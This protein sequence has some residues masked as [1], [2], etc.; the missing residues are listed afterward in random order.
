MGGG[1][2]STI[3]YYDKGPAVGLL[4]DLA[5]RHSTGNRQSL[6]DVMRRLYREFY[7][8]KR[9]GFTD[10]EFRQVC[11]SVAGT[12]LQEIFEYVYTVKEPDYGKY[13][14]YG[15]LGIDSEWRIFDVPDPGTQA[16]AIRKS[17]LGK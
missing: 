7:Q 3:S 16:L 12:S 6:D 2:D 8:G 9:R 10:A 4:L 14:A 17:L 5:I 1:A 11:E 13:L 15:G